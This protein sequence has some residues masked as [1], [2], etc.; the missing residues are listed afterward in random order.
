MDSYVS[1]SANIHDISVNG[2]HE[3]MSPYPWPLAPLGLAPKYLSSRES[4]AG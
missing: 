1:D 3:F 2:L 4:E